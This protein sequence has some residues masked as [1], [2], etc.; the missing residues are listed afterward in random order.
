MYGF[1]IINVVGANKS[2]RFSN[3]MVNEFLFFS[4]AA[5]V[6]AGLANPPTPEGSGVRVVI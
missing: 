5:A 6:A 1:S 2:F 3:H 4:G